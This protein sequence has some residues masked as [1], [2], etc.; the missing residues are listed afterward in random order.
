MH[1]KEKKKKKIYRDNYSKPTWG[2]A[3]FHFAYPWFKT[4]HFAHL[5]LVPLDFHNPSFCLLLEKTHF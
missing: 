3:R 4:L 5:K 2:M 1:K